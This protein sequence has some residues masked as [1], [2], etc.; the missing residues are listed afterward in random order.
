MD[1]QGFHVVAEES[2]GRV[3][4]DIAPLQEL[5]DHRLRQG[6]IAE[7]VQLVPAVRA[8]VV[9]LLLIA[10]GGCLRDLLIR[11]QRNAHGSTSSHC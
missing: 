11:Y 3:A 8:G 10:L 4:L 2:E 1:S 7:L 9:P 6:L 5:G